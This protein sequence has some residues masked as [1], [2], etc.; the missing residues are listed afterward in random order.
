LWIFCSGRLW[1][2]VLLISTSHLSRITSMCH[3]VWSTS[4]S[5]KLHA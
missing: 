4:V 1:T 5:F 3:C 2:T